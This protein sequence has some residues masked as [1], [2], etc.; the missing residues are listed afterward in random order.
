MF[1]A[2]AFL[3]SLWL[4]RTE[5]FVSGVEQEYLRIH[6]TLRKD[7]PESRSESRA[8]NIRPRAGPGRAFPCI[9]Q[10]SRFFLPIQQILPQR[11]IH[12][13]KRVGAEQHRLEVRRVVVLQSSGIRIQWPKLDLMHLFQ[14]SGRR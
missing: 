9:G 2:P 7:L 12:R 8:I 10:R 5:S 6:I 13:L 3:R 1:I 14:L 11:L 4:V